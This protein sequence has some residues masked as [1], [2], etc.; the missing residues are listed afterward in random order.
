MLNCE[1]TDVLLSGYLDAELTQQD[2]QRVEVHL[3]GCELCRGK[4]D[5]LSVLRSSVRKL[6]FPSM[7]EQQKETMMNSSV[8]KGSQRLGW[9]LIV[10]GM[11][12]A[13]GF[14]MWKLG[15]ALFQDPEVPNVVTLAILGLYAGFGF[16]LLSAGL[17]RLKT[18]GTDR[19]K[20]VE[21]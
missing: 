3:D 20:D 9:L 11:L 21:L 5:E 19:Y 6:A 13:G 7:S 12:V 2:R 18:Y 8:A 4:L 16:L 14:G 15:E 1:S 17:H 10:F